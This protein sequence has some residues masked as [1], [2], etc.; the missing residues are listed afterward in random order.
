MYNLNIIFCK[1]DLNTN[2]NVDKCV[3][4]RSN[5]TE[6]D[7]G[8]MVKTNN[9]EEINID[10]DDTDEDEVVEGK[11]SCQHYRMS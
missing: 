4:F 11:S 1:C 7:L 2:I 10:E 5:T 8:D 3:F 9:P 6:Q